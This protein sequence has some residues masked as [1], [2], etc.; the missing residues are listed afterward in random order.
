MQGGGARASNQRAEGQRSRRAIPV[1]PS[2]TGNSAAAKSSVPPQSPPAAPSVVATPVQLDP[3]VAYKPVQP[4]PRE[5]AHVGATPATPTL[6]RSTSLGSLGYAQ[7]VCF[8]FPLVE[9]FLACR[10]CRW[11]CML[12]AQVTPREMLDEVCKGVR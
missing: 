6:K 4:Q 1:G 8:C 2:S 3:V 10:R 7:P 9:K 11:L 12:T 5:D